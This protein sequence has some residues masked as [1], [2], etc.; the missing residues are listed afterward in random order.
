MVDGLSG[1]SAVTRQWV[2]DVPLA[3]FDSHVNLSSNQLE[4]RGG[5]K[6]DKKERETVVAVNEGRSKRQNE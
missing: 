3:S 4:K 6:E 5:T 2:V 1:T